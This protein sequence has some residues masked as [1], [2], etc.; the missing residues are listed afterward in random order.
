MYKLVIILLL[1]GMILAP[2]TPSAGQSIIPLPNHTETAGGKLQYPGFLKIGTTD[3][4]FASLIPVI[5]KTAKDYYGIKVTSKKKNALVSL[6]RNPE[7]RN[8]EAYKLSVTPSGISIEAGSSSGCF[9]GLQ[10]LLQMVNG[11]TP[12]SFMEGTLIEDTPLY[13]WRGLMLDESR[14]FF[15]EDEVKQ[16]LDLM[17]IHKLNKFHWHLTDVPGWRIEIKQYPLLTTVGGK[18]NHTDPN[19]PARY[20][21][22]AQISEI[23]NYA[24]ER[25]IEVIPEIDMPGHATAAVKAYPEFSGGGSAKYPEFTFNPGKDGTYTFLTNILREVMQLFPSP[26]IHIGGDEVHFGNEKWAELPDVKKLMADNR[27]KDLVAVEHYFLDRMADSIRSISR[28][29]IG[30]DEVVTAGMK[31]DNTLV[32]WWRHDKTALLKEALEK[33]YEVVLCPRI[34][35]YFDFVQE[36]SHQSGRKWAGSFAP[37]ESVYAFPSETFTGGVSPFS[38]GVKGIQANVWTE[39]IHSRERLHFM[40]YPRLSALAEAAWTSEKRK[41]FKGFNIRMN[42]MFKLY[43]RNNI[44]YYDP[45][46]PEKSLE[47]KGLRP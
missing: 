33:N 29:V 35:L 19:A 9:Y 25:F 26:Y 41:D 18:G 31:P 15:G 7:I 40:L 21:S 1:A 2:A 17:A 47:I 14:H 8:A 20:Y 30:W 13:P 27:L 3:G 4:E 11:L 37:L 12:G 42:D 32:M 46:N 43:Q 24:S 38:Q 44:G 16:V 45:N 34:P 5:A 36:E 22:Q 23:V 28:H 10:S 6:I 39:E